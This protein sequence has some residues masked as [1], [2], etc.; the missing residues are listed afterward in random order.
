[1]N[2]FAY[3]LMFWLLLLP[4]A[5]FLLFPK[6]TGQHGSA[7]SVPFLADLKLIKNK[8]ERMQF[9]GIGRN[10]IFSLKFIYLFSIWGLLTVAAARPQFI[11]EPYRLKAENRDIMLVLDISTSMLQPDFSTRNQRIDRLSAV[12]AVVSSFIEKRTEDRLGLIL[13]GT[14]AYLQSPLTFDRQAIQEIL[15]NTDA[16]MAGN[17][18]SI[19]DALGLALKNLKDEKDKSNKVIILLSDGESNDGFLSMA[20][21]IDLAEK[22]GIKVYTIGVGAEMNFIGS[23]FGIRNN[24]LDEKSLKEL[25]QRTKGNYFRAKDLNSLAEIYQKINN[26]EPQNNEGNIVQEKK[27]LFYIPL[28]AALVLTAFLIFL[29]RRYMK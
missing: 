5:V 6:V 10:L 29:P 19:G 26:L 25:A 22:E 13:F 12:K 28:A 16:G 3:P 15:Y 9:F 18:T 20:Q 24:E 1:M 2:Y 21:A 4:F 17:S 8:T 23:I 27:D 14:R 11:G 7:L